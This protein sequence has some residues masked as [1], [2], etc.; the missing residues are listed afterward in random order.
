MDGPSYNL[1]LRY[2]FADVC[3]LE[4]LEQLARGSDDTASVEAR[5][6]SRGGRAEEVQSDHRGQRA[7]PE[8]LK[9]EN[10]PGAT[11]GT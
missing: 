9:R 6:I 11:A 4:F 2:P 8:R 3:E 10:L 7:R 1:T 5:D